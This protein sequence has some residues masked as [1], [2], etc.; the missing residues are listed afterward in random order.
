MKIKNLSKKIFINI[1]IS[2][3]SIVLVLVLLEPITIFSLPYLPL[4]LQAYLEPSVRILCQN[5]K[6]GLIPENY[7][8]IIGDSYAQGYGDWLFNSNQWSNPKFHSAHLINSLLNKDVV[9]FGTAGSGSIESIVESFIP[10]ITSIKKE[11]NIKD[12]KI[13]LFYFYEGNDLQDD[14]M[15]LEH[16]GY[17]KNTKE[18]NKLEKKEFYSFLEERI[19][20]QTDHVK[21]K[22]ISLKLLV[23]LIKNALAKLIYKKNIETISCHEPKKDPNKYNLVEINKKSVF[24]PD[25]IQAPPVEMYKDE[26][27]LGIR[28]FKYSLEY[29]INKFPKSS[30]AVIYIPS[31]ISCYHLKSDVFVHRSP[32][33]KNRKNVYSYN[34]IEKEGNDLVKKINTV[35]N[36]YKVN[37]FNTSPDLKLTASKKLIHGPCDI[38]HFNKDGYEAFSK[39]IVSFLKKEKLII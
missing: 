27:D 7:I 1:C 25:D 10:K 34:L 33:L 15:Y 26:I 22:P 5:S 30:I 3:I 2:I 24:L 31:V 11:F 37:F 29:L 20:S 17:F 12:P 14:L 18:K 38:E 4:N 8:A 28:T 35:C 9:S 13:I 16:H 32:F 36:Y 6:K 23:G 21:Y 19:K 39:S